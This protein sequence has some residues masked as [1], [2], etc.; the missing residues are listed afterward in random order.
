MNWLTLV[1]S[2]P[3]DGNTPRMRAWRALKAAGA[4]ALRDGVYLLPALPGQAELLRSIGDDV[5]GHGGEA[6]LLH[7]GADDELADLP[8]RFDRQDAWQEFIR[9]VAGAA[10]QLT[11]NANQPAGVTEMARVA[12]RLHKHFAQLAAIDFFPGTPQQHAADALRELVSR[13]ARAENPDEPQA[14][15]DDI[16]R[17]DAAGFQRRIWATR[18]RPRIDR[19]ASAWLIHRFIDAGAT[20]LWLASPT[21]C[22]RDAVGFD[23][24]GATFTHTGDRV[25]FE[26]LLAA[27]SLETPALKQMAAIVHFLDVGGI[28]PPEAG[29]IERVLRGLRD[30]ITDDDELLRAALPLFDGLHKDFD[31]LT[32]NAD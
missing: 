22:P 30:S 7:V 32:H 12:R 27:F 14:Q 16:E 24:D 23:F 28:A 31:N 4:A 6:W 1:L 5:R 29:G 2:L 26:T 20:F 3:A 11:L 18:A 9:E 15:A 25:T 10:Q 21:D 19:L 8:A 17:R 13:I